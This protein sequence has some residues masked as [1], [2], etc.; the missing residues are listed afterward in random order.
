M[1]SK[2]EYIPKQ[3]NVFAKVVG[4]R[5]GLLLNYETVTCN[6]KAEIQEYES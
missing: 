5:P 6:G 3:I 2:K 1:F 4:K